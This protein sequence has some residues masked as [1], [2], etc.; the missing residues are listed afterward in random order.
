VPWRLIHVLVIRA[1]LAG[2]DNSGRGSSA[3]AL[4]VASPLATNAAVAVSFLR[5]ALTVSEINHTVMAGIPVASFAASA[6][7]S[8]SW[9]SD[10]LRKFQVGAQGLIQHA[11]ARVEVTLIPPGDFFM[12]YTT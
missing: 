12:L 3:N 5:S 4:A 11:R 10:A 7:Q 8:C 6:G 9:R 1:S 2:W